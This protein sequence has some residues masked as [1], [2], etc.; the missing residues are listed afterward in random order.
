[1]GVIRWPPAGSCGRAV[2][3]DARLSLFICAVLC[4]VLRSGFSD[5]VGGHAK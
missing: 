2:V 3:G 4:A 5:T 1:M